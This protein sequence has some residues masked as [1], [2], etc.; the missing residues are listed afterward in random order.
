MHSDSFALGIRWP[1]FEFHFWMPQWADAQKP[2]VMHQPISAFNSPVP[3]HLSSCCHFLSQINNHIRI[4]CL[5]WSSTLQH[6]H[7]TFLNKGCSHSWIPSQ[8]IETR[9]P[10]SVVK[11][12]GSWTIMPIRTYGK[13]SVACIPPFHYDHQLLAELEILPFHGDFVVDLPCS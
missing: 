3:M 4:Y 8:W 9:V 5:P 7:S 10:S 2:W 12:L 1:S 6:L 13:R 11:G